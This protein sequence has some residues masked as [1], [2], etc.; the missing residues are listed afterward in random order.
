[1]RLTTR[2]RSS[3]ARTVGAA[4]LHKLG[5]SVRLFPDVRSVDPPAMNEV[6]AVLLTDVVDSTGLSDARRRGDG[7]AVGRPRSPGARPP[8]RVARPRNR[9]ERR[10]AAAVRHR[11]R[12][13]SATRSPTT[14]RSPALQPAAGARGPARR[15][16]HAAREHARRHRA[17][18]QAA[19]G[20]RPRQADRGARHVDR[21]GRAD[22]ADRRGARGARRAPAALAVARPLAPE[23]LPE[24]LELFEVGEPTRVRAAA[25]YRQGLPRR[26]PRRPV[27]AA[28]QIRHGLPAERDA[29]IGRGDALDELARRLL[30]GARLVSRARHRRHRQD[31]AGACASAGPG[32]ATSPGGV[33]FCDLSQAPSLDGIVDA[34]GRGLDVPLGREDPVVQLGHAIA[35]RG[36]CLVILDNFEQVA[37]ARRADGRALARSGAARPGSS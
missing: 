11:G 37:R 8:S 31:A 12:R 27:A 25:R 32:S 19:R 26:P 21:A 4:G 22:P 36:R 33:W 17:R 6:R 2:G 29:F 30:G 9:Q 3:H 28:R 20:R 7:G 35:G 15:A 13:A 14:A 23:G 34:V 5:R 1:M 24:P 18:R 10:L 16:G